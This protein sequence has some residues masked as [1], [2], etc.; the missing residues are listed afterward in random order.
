MPG[1]RGVK[2]GKVGGRGEIR[3]EDDGEVSVNEEREGRGSEV[4]LWK[5][6]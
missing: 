5:V 4:K 1:V 3:G 2:I 6:K